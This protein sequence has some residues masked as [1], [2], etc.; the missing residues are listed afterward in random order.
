MAKETK[1]AMLA[2]RVTPKLKAVL[3]QLAEAERRSTATQAEILL[4][5]GLEKRGL[6]PSAGKKT[7]R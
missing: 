5:E 2:I 1:T 7:Q 3:D 6:W 4:E